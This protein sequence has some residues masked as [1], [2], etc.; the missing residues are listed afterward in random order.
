V[1][2]ILATAVAVAQAAAPPPA[3]DRTPLVVRHANVW[4]PAGILKD[5]D[6][7]VRDGRVVEIAAASGRDPEGVRTLDAAGH[8]LLPGLVDAH[9][10][11]V[12][13]GGLPPGSPAGREAAVTGRQ[14]LQAGVTSGRLHL[15]SVESAVDLKAR[16]ANDCEAVPRLQAGGPGFSGAAQRDYPNFWGVTSAADAAAKVGRVA[17]AGLDWIALHDAERFEPAVLDALASAAR[18]RGLRLMGAG[19][20]AAQIEAV[21]RANPDTLD[22]FLRDAPAEYPAPLLAAIRR[23][24]RLILAPTFGIQHRVARYAA[25]PAGLDDPANYAFLEPAERLFVTEAARGALAKEAAGRDV[26]GFQ[27]KAAQLRELGLPLAIASDVGSPLHFQAG[28]IWSELEGWRALGFSHREALT[29][30]TEGA[31]RVLDAADAGRLGTGSRADFV[32]YRG[33]V[34]NGPFDA[35]RVLAVAKGGVLFVRG[36][37]WSG[38]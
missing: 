36:G 33:D 4:T 10:H 12:V 16:G 1:I 20:G 22:Y 9:L 17:D 32:L 34:E 35:G 38:P 26:P 31:A 5:R 6:V 19:T 37:T 30:A 29:A 18:G 24:P 15:A 21:L 25:Q 28:G 8:T 14:L 27:R 2:A 11:F 7:V 23:H 13:P 3:C